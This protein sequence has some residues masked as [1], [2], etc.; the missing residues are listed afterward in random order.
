M[1]VAPIV[2]GTDGS[3]SA[4]RAVERAGE[5]GLALGAAVHVVSVCVPVAH[6]LAAA[7]AGSFAPVITD[8]EHTRRAARTIVETACAGL[9]D[10]GVQAAAHVYVGDPA[11]GLIS[12]ADATAAQIIVVGNRGM[13]GARRVLGSVPNDVSHRAR[14][15]VMIVPTS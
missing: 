9:A 11:D 13:A 12:V 4:C 7:V 2:V 15:A 10:S 6:G 8:D 14:C 3:P 5:L 1:P